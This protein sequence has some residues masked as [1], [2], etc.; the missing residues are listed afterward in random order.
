MEQINVLSIDGGGIRGIIPAIILAEIEKRTKR[1]VS[2]LFHLVAGTSTGGIIALAMGKP[3][4]NG[5]PEYKA[6]DLETFYVNKGPIIFAHSPWHDFI[7]LDHL[8]GPKYSAG[9]IEDVLAEFFKNS[10]LSESLCDLLITSYDIEV[11]D[12]F[13]FKSSRAKDDRNYNFPMKNV[14]RATSAAP[15]YFEPYKLPSNDGKGYFPLVDGGVV[16]NNPSQCAF[17]EAQTLYPDANDILVISLGTG[18]QTDPYMYD[19]A[20]DWGLVKWASPLLHILFDAAST[21][22]HYELKQLLPNGVDSMPR[23]YR[24]QATLDSKNGS[25]DNVSPENMRALQLVARHIIS[26]NDG[27]IDQICAQLKARKPI[28]SKTPVGSK[29]PSPV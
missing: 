2:D 18:G 8:T 9:P 3:G 17:M 4:A 26:D 27:Q 14:A 6:K 13:L 5:S 15:T 11:R 28:K 21:T 16:A 10:M 24:L 29:D 19:D 25:L 12:P 22:A 23:Y 7:T 20:K 1:S